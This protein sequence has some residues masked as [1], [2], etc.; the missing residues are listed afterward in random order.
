MQLDPGSVPSVL[1]VREL[2]EAGG[3]PQTEPCVRDLN[4]GGTRCHLRELTSRLLCVSGLGNLWEYK[5]LLTAW[6]HSIYK[7]SKLVF[8]TINHPM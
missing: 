5:P 7:Y 3:A 4:P 6:S 2:W 1:T 8:I